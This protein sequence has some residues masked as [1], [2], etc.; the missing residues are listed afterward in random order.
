MG[1]GVWCDGS[2]ATGCG[3]STDSQSSTPLLLSH[4]YTRPPSALSTYSTAAV[5]RAIQARAAKP[6][7][8]STILFTASSS[9]SSWR[10]AAPRHAG[11]LAIGCLT[12]RAVLGIDRGHHAVDRDR[13]NALAFLLHKRS[14]ADKLAPP[15]WA[16]HQPWCG[17]ARWVLLIFRAASSQMNQLL[18]QRTARHAPKPVP[19]AR[20]VCIQRLDARKHGGKRQPRE[21]HGH[22]EEI[23]RSEGMFNRS[24]LAAAHCPGPAA[25]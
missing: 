13:H 25:T 6:P 7:S 10:Q 12:E 18:A 1:C 21:Q 24:L 9:R 14:I 22:L 11:S 19:L 16:C 2:S 5:E 3:S 8:R 17:V 15:V 20:L 23:W 4:A